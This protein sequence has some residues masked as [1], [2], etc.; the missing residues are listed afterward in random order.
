MSAINHDLILKRSD[1]IRQGISRIQEYL[2][3]SLDQFVSDPKLIA[4][5][6][7]ESLVVIE[8]AIAICTHLASNVGSR[9]PENYPDCFLV[10]RESDIIS[11]DLASRLVFMARFRNLIV[12]RYWQIDDQ[13]VY[14]VLKS[15][16]PDLEDFLREI[17]L[18]LRN[19]KNDETK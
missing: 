18:F 11:E 9:V 1:E 4:A 16:L 7:Y 6:K 3:V 17:G 14:N 5:V 10:L 8:A 15:D 2:Q 19:R 12:H 13:R